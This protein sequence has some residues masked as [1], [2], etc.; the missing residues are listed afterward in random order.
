MK[1]RPEIKMLAKE[2][3]AQQR[4]TSILIL[5]LVGV[6]AFALSMLGFIP[7]FGWIISIAGSIFT[8]VLAV[9][10]AGTFAMIYRK[11][12]ADV[13]TPFNML[14]VNFLRKLGGSYWMGLWT[15]LWSLLFVI[16]GII[17]GYSYLLTTYILADCP[18][19]KATDA[20]KLS[21]RMT[22]GYKAEL[23]VMHLSFI[24]WNLLG[25]LTLGILSIVYVGPY[26]SITEAG[27]YVEL[28]D[29]AIASGVIRAEELQ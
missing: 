15:V 2:A 17:K 10:M 24:G 11:E 18:N 4:A 9:N 21:M 3:L 14:S 25:A 6:I 19:V 13:A 26:I 22:S 28:R 5:L 1:S 20:L 12:K 7:F 27:F 8:A 16:P 23:F 29:R